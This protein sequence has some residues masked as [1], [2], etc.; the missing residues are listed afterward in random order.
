MK[1]V[2]VDLDELIQNILSDHKQRKANKIDEAVSISVFSTG[3]ADEEQS[4]SGINGHFIHSQLLIDCLIR[5]K[6]TSNDKT[7]LISFC[8]KEYEGNNAELKILEEFERDYSP[9]D[10]LRWYTR[11]SCLYRFL[12][13][14]LR[15]QNIDLLFL[16]RF[17]IRDIQRQT[18]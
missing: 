16:F 13:K 5:M 12:N 11:E 9:N 4:T 17:F 6:S 2:I 14:V 7:E 18:R 1:A 10:A 8:R 15:V 3:G